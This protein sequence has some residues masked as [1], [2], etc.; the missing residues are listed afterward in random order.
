M[1]ISSQFY[2]RIC[3]V[4]LT[5][6]YLNN[7]YLQWRNININIITNCYLLDTF[8]RYAYHNM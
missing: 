6:R 2:I 4:L 8:V 7:A 3:L 5:F 1:L